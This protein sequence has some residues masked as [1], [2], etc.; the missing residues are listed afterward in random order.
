MCAFVDMHLN[1][2]VCFGRLNG[3]K[4]LDVNTRD[5]LLE[6]ANEVFVFTFP[7]GCDGSV[8]LNSKGK[9]KA[10][11]D[12][13][14]NGSLHA[15]YVIDSAK[16]QIEALCP[17]V[18]SCADILAFAARDAVVLVGLT[19]FKILLNSSNKYFFSIAI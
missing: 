12:A 1:F 15:F 4:H 6:L 7:Q 13:P 11:K 8:L 3:E 9:S 2:D 5:R 16:K 10:E 14:P 17:G 18:V 19:K